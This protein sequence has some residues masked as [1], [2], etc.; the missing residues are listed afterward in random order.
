[1]HLGPD[2]YCPKCGVKIK[3]HRGS[4]CLMPKVLST[5]TNLRVENEELKKKVADLTYELLHLDPKH[6][7]D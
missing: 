1:M 6:N 3:H 2:D 4:P 7:L 5:E